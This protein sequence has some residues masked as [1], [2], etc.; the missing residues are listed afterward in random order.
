VKG[1]EDA[2][3]HEQKVSVADVEITDFDQTPEAIISLD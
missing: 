1:W 3:D 2:A